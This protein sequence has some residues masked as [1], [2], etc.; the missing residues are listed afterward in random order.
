MVNLI[1]RHTV[2]GYDRELA[3]LRALVLGMG[4]QVVEQ[5]QDAVKSLL[6]RDLYG[7]ER[8]IERERDIDYLQLDADEAIFH[9]ISK[10]QPVAIDLRFVL[11]LS[12]VA[13]ELERAADK[14]E[15]IATS[16]RSLVKHQA[17]DRANALPEVLAGVR[18]L[19]ALAC[20]MLERG[21]EALARADID[22]ALD[23]FATQPRLDQAMAETSRLLI[24]HAYADAA[25]IRDG[26]DLGRALNAIQRIGE[27]GGNIAEQVIFI[28][29]GKDIR[30]QNREILIDA[31]RT[32]K[33][34]YE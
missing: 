10:R 19:F 15:Q 32:R 2:S 9:L 27:H 11:A 4:D 28:A 23:V 16:A 22:R 33:G 14:A 17:G 24:G 18:S 26:F 29:K 20:P 34:R 6:G 31:L 5:T 1:G 25:S 21:I 7:A 12:K 3:E 13:D 8:V 30:Y